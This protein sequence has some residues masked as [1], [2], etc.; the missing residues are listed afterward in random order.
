MFHVP[1]RLISHAV[2]CVCRMHV[3]CTWFFRKGTP[4]SQWEFELTLNVREKF[5]RARADEET[6]MCNS[7]FG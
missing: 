5:T 4:L 6:R 1:V 2:L 3:K 7:S